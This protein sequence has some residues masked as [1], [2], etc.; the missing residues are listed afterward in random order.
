M[1]KNTKKSIS[2]E[3]IMGEEDKLSLGLSR[4]KDNK[5]YEFFARFDGE[6]IEGQKILVCHGKMVSY[7]KWIEITKE[8]LIICNY[9]S[10][11]DPPLRLKPF[12]H[13]LSV[14]N[15]V[16]VTIICDP[17][18]ETRRVILK[19]DGGEFTLDGNYFNSCDGVICAYGE[20]I[21]LT[22]ATLSM[23]AFGYDHDIWIIGASY[24][25]LFDPSRWPHYWYLDGGAGPFLSG[26]GGMGAQHGME[27]LLDALKYGTPKILMWDS[28][29]GNNPDKDDILSPLFYDNTLEML[30]ICKEKGIKV[31]IQTMPNCPIQTNLYKNDVILNRTLEF[32]NYD[33]EIVDLARALGAK[34]EKN[35]SWY[36]GMLY[37]D[38]V[39]PRQLGAR[40]SY[41]AIIVDAPELILGR[42]ADVF[43]KTAQT[44]SKDKISI[45]GTEVCDDSAITFRADFN[46][47]FDGKLVIGNGESEGSYLV[48]DKDNISVYNLSDGEAKLTS[49]EANPAVMEELVNLKIKIKDGKASIALM[50]V[51]EKDFSLETPKTRLDTIVA[52]W[53]ASGEVYASVSGQQISDVRIKLAK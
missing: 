18:T 38:N 52:D 20:N 25:S 39:H 7:G 51:S 9:T 29:S 35:P 50:S 8:E 42:A 23:K 27:D 32:A 45:R 21:I 47:A 13:G 1:E 16:E 10:W 17:I 48:I 28:V 46:G 2:A 11:V 5:R 22:D 33:Y 24:L 37:T 4:V 31:Y 19:T 26:R 3:K 14:K 40:A 15:F 43:T 53:K 49:K 6:L 41:L 12:A 36:P 44:L 30:K 34:A